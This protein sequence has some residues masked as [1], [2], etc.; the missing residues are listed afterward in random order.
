M[1]VKKISMF[2]YLIVNTHI[3][4]VLVYVYDCMYI[5]YIHFIKYQNKYYIN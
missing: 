2:Y 4:Q 3:K 5:M 1:E